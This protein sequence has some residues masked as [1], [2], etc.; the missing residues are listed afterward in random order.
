MS[1]GYRE[2]RDNDREESTCELMKLFTIYE[3]VIHS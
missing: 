3:T 1:P 2:L